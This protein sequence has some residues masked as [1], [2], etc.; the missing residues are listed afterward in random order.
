MILS[1]LPADSTNLYLFLGDLFVGDGDE[2]D[3]LG[4]SDLKLLLRGPVYG[5][6]T[7]S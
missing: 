3:V 1:P 2:D 5:S 4:L 7:S 6:T